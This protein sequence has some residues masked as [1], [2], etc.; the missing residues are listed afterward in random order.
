MGRKTLAVLL[1]AIVAGG[2]A[3]AQDSNQDRDRKIEQ[4]E[5]EIARIRD[6]YERRLESLEGELREMKKREGESAIEALRRRAAEAAERSEKEAAI[7][8]AAVRL[9]GQGSIVSSSANAFNPRITVFGDF[10][11]RLDSRRVPPL[12]GD[13]DEDENVG[14]RF[15]LRELEIDF[16]AD[17]DPYAKGVAIIAFEEEFGEYETT[18][19]EAY[20][21]LHTIPGL[22]EVRHNLR[23]KVGRFRTEFGVLNRLHTHDLMWSSRPLPFIEFLGPEGDVGQGVGV[24]YLVHNPFEEAISLTFQVVNGENDELFA[25]S[26]S[27]DVALLGRLAWQKHLGDEHDF[28]LGSSVYH[29]NAE[30]EF[31]GRDDRTREST[32]LGFDGYYRWR[33]REGRDQTSFLLNTEWYIRHR[34]EEFDGMADD[35]MRWGFYVAA[36]YQFLKSFYAGTRFDYLSGDERARDDWSWKGAAYLSYYTTEFLRFRIGYEHEEDNLGFDNDTLFLQV[37]WVFGSHPVEPYWFNK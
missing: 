13:G 23:F 35:G 37:T 9:A 5:Q 1:A 32:L 25:G 12:E 36:Q 33:P 14:D 10:V 6:L 27:N 3:H 19:E 8:A 24:E 7:D 29:G 17:I 30:R 26:A 28:Q 15:S 22:E 21:D 2:A 4:L 20:I 16:R 34:E 31:D 11:G 18:V